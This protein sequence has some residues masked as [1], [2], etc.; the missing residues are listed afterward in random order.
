MLIIATGSSRW[1]I[2]QENTK[3]PVFTAE[4]DFLILDWLTG[5]WALCP[6]PL[7]T[8]FLRFNEWFYFHFL[9]HHQHIDNWHYFKVHALII[10]G[11]SSLLWLVLLLVVLAL[12]HHRTRLSCW[13]TLLLDLL[14]FWTRRYTLKIRASA[15]PLVKRIDPSHWA[16]RARHRSEY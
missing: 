2:R 8:R 1:K 5:R 9:K 4:I 11:R 15:C 13:W 6:S 10:I 3:L 7:F 14:S 16:P 12:I